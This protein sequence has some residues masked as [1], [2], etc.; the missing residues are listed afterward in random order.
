MEEEEA[1]VEEGWTKTKWIGADA[2][3]R[4][5]SV[6]HTEPTTV[7]RREETA[8]TNAMTV[9]MMPPNHWLLMMRNQGTLHHKMTRV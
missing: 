4:A 2:T 3:S 1:E 8:T 5:S 9:L 6:V 7:P